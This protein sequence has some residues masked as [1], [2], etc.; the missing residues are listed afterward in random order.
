MLRKLAEAIRDRLVF[1]LAGWA[2]GN[3]RSGREAAAMLCTVTC[4]P[5][6]E[7]SGYRSIS[8]PTHGTCALCAL[9]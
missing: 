7:L 4:G 8:M 9:D 1:R 2:V 6:S 3:P 5:A